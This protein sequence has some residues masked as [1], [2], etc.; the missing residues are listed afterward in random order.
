M[1]T[2]CGVSGSRGRASKKSIPK[3]VA[4]KTDGISTTNRNREQATLPRGR[5]IRSQMIAEAAYFI[6]QERGFTGG[7]PLEDWLSAETQIDRLLGM[8]GY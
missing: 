4:K 1:T 7:S 2:T 3:R 5:P 8:Q 6:A